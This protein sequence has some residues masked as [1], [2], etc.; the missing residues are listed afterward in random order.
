M[1]EK[2]ETMNPITQMFIMLCVAII[3]FPVT[4]M[5]YG[6]LGSVVLFILLII[7]CLFMAKG[8]YDD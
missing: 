2:D 1:N 3:G 5:C 6:P 7:S 4:L 8:N